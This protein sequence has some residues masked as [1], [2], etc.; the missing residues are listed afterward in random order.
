MRFRLP[1]TI[2]LFLNFLSLLLFSFLILKCELIIY[3]LGQLKGQL[4][5]I[6]YTQPIAEALESSSYTL[7]EK[8]KLTLV[9]KVKSFAEEEL[10]FR[11]TKNFQQVCNQNK[12]GKLWV[13]EACELFSFKEYTWNFPIVGEVTYKGYFDRNKINN[14]AQRLRKK[15]YDSEV[16]QVS[17]WS[18][19]GIL[20][21]PILSENLK[22][23][24]YALINLI[25]HE[26]FHSTFYE[27][28]KVELNE[29]L[30]NFL[31]HKA[32]LLFLAK[33]SISLQFYKRRMKDDS[34]FKSE[35]LKQKALLDN[36]YQTL[37]PSDTLENLKKRQKIFNQSINRIFN[38]PYNDRKRIEKI[39]SAIYESGN[40][41]FTGVQKYDGL[42]DSLDKVLKNRFKNDLKAMVRYF[43]SS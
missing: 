33:D 9:Q 23:K 30:A 11:K 20:S 31:A 14:E 42:Q 27:S 6:Y 12:S 7:E 39:C 41:F 26:L 40:C 5:T 2:K 16:S 38:H 34:L 18:T 1:H 25:F 15:G 4:K 32:T 36:F 21:D 35:V 29:N 37:H 22:L 19:L 8:E 3:G 43:K 10:D 13:L 28:S 17:A 24:P